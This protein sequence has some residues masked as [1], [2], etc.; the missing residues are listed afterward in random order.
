M[1]TH[2]ILDL[3]LHHH[4]EHLQSVAPQAVNPE[5]MKTGLVVIPISTSNGDS[6]KS[7]IGAGA[8]AGIIISLLVVTALLVA[9]FLFKRKKSKRSS[10]MDIEKTD[11]QPFTLASNDFHGM[12]TY[13]LHFAFKKVGT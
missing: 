2:S 10:S 13:T 9:F 5:D 3:R 11:N 4:L 1:A 6:K 8:I 12:H 7:G